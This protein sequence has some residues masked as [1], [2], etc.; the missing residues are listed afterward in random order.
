MIMGDADINCHESMQ[1]LKS[2]SCFPTK[3]KEASYRKHQLGNSV[4][5][6]KVEEG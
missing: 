1:F 5:F 6:V 3:T 2:L 4:R